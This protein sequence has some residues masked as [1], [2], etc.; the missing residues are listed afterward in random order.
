M[1]DKLLIKFI[2]PIFLLGTP[3]MV[4]AETLTIAYGKSKPPFVTKSCDDGIEVDLAREAFQRANYK[5]EEFCM[6]NRRMIYSYVNGTID[7]GVSVPNDEKGMFYTEVFS[8]FENLVVTRTSDYIIIDSIADLGH[9]SSVA[10]NNAQAVLGDEFAEVV[11]NNPKYREH[12]SQIAQVKMFLSGRVDAI[13]IDK[14]IFLWL[15]NKLIE[16]GELSNINT[17]FTYHRIFSE[18]VNY[19]IGFSNEKHAKKINDALQ[20]MRRD[21]TYQEIID[22]YIPN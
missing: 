5:I 21:G 2:F 9:I 14:N 18:T 7:A 1:R 22:S 12:V 10:W 20:S 15:T 4:T 11:R 19:Y 3:I 6:V 16:S 13:I 8:S 17:T